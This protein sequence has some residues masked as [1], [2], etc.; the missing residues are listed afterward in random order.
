[1][2]AKTKSIKATDWVQQEAKI[3]VAKEGISLLEFTDT[4]MISML[5][6]KGHKITLRPK[7]TN[8][9]KS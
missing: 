7:Q 9:A 8:K 4:A 5:T 3:F 1:M 6:L 2:K